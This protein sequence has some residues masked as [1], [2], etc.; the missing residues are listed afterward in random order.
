MDD[1]TRHSL[2]LMPKSVS[3]YVDDVDIVG[4]VRLTSALRGSDDDRKKIVSDGSRE[5][6]CSATAASVAKNR[7]GI[8]EPM[9]L[10]EGE[11]PLIAALRGEYEK[12]QDK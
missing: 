8:T 3:H 1:Y 10:K 11:N 4:F 6:V 2:R 12:E 5:L 9:P 7:Y